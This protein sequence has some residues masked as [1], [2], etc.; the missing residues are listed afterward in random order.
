MKKFIAGL[1]I[2][3]LLASAA[4]G[5]ASLDPVKIFVDGEEIFPD[6]PPRIIDGRVMV[7]AR[8]IAEPLGAEVE[9]DGENRFVLIYSEKETKEREKEGMIPLRELIE[10]YG[11]EYGLTAAGDGYVY[12]EGEILFS[13]EEKGTVIDARIYVPED[14]VEKYIS[15]LEKGEFEPEP[16]PEPE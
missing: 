13:W 2:G 5:M 1:I 7:P 15:K 16:E 10:K 4:V 6:V 9:W 8:F 14:I 3:L 11:E 12:R